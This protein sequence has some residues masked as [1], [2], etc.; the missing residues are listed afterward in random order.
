[1]MT[2]MQRKWIEDMNRFCDE[3]FDLSYPRQAQEATV[4]IDRNLEEYQTL[5]FTNL[6]LNGGH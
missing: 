3:K 2:D 4:Y 6:V 1:M 5:M